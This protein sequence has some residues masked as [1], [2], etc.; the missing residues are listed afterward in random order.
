MWCF[1]LRV[2]ARARDIHTYIFLVSFPNG[3]FKGNMLCEH[4]GCEPSKDEEEEKQ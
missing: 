1:P 2:W 3:L 4:M